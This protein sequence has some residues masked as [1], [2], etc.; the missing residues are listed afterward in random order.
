MAKIFKIFADFYTGILDNIYNMLS[1]FDGIGGE[2][3]ASLKDLIGKIL[4]KIK[5]EDEAAEEAE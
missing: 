3:F 5:G 1:S 2:T 4:G